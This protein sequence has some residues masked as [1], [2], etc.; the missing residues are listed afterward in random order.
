MAAINNVELT[1]V[2]DVANALITLAYDVEFD[3]FDRTTNLGYRESWRYF[4][5]DTGFDGDLLGPDDQ[6]G[7]GATL[8]NPVHAD[9]RQSVHR[10]R[11][12]TIAW[13]DLDEDPWWAGEDEIRGE[14]TVKPLLP[15]TTV[16]ESNLVTVDA[17]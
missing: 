7:P 2:K 16:A 1:I 10:V 6:I 12:R 5:D 8:L 3:E 4:G 9:G 11:E 13:A 14:V 17:P 15:S